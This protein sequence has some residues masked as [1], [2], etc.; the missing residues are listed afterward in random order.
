MAIQ[1]LSIFVENQRGKLAQIMQTLAAGGVDIRALS[2]ADTADYGILRLIVS[3][4]A[5]AQ[6]LLEKS[7]CVLSVTDVLA[8]AVP[9]RPGAF[10]EVVQVLSQGDI[11]LEYV[12]AFIT[13]RKGQAY[14]VVRVKDNEAAATA[15]AAAGITLLTDAQLHECFDK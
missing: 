15:L 14:V 3:D 7:N 9:D 1:Q 6:A 11:N 8:V 12:Y 2:L 10:A 5:R 13:P 4:T